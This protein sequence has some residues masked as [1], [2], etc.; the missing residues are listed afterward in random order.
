MSTES[1]K[2]YKIEVWVTA[3]CFII[4]ALTG[5]F[6]S[7]FVVILNERFFDSVPTPEQLIPHYGESMFVVKEGLTVL[8]F[9]LH[10]FLLIMLSWI[11]ATIIGAIWCIVMDRLE[12]KQR[13]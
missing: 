5:G 1:R 4:V 13:A 8:G 12:D 7:S 6:F 9:P 3:I 11:G 2:V 10:Y